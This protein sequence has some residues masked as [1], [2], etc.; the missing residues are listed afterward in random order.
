MHFQ[1]VFVFVEHLSIRLKEREKKTV[2]ESFSSNL[3]H[4]KLGG[5]L[6]RKSISIIIE[7]QTKNIQ[8]I[9]PS[10]MSFCTIFQL[11]ICLIE[12]YL[13]FCLLGE[14]SATNFI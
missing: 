2:Q 8:A 9:V 4:L 13:K 12:K 7:P 3:V 11:T 5:T 1:S 14:T 10:L 6:L